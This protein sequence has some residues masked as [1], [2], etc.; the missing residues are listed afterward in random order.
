MLKIRKTI[1]FMISI[2]MLI[3][4]FGSMSVLAAENG[5]NGIYYLTKAYC[6]SSSGVIDQTNNG[7][8]QIKISQGVTAKIVVQVK[9]LSQM[10]S[11]RLSYAQNGGTL[12]IKLS[13]L[14]D[15]G[16][17]SGTV[18]LDTT[19]TGIESNYNTRLTEGLAFSTRA[20]G[21]E[22]YLLV[23]LICG[24]SRDN[25]SYID[26][27][28]LVGEPADFTEPVMHITFDEAGT[29]T[30]SFTANSGGTIIENGIVS[31]V[32][33]ENG[34]KA[35]LIENN[36]A[37]NYLELPTGILNGAEAA[38]V[39]MWVKP[40]SR[41]WPFMT[42]TI[43]EG[44]QP[45][46]NEKY[47]G[48]ISSPT[49][50]TAQRYNNSG[51]RR[52][53]LIADGDYTDWKNV[54]AV[55][56]GN[57]AKIYVDGKL[58]ATD[59]TT[60][61]VKNLMTATARTWIGHANWGTGEGFSGMIDD[62]KLYGRA[63]SEDEVKK[64][65]FENAGGLE[66]PEIVTEP[67]VL[68]KS[69]GGNPILRADKDGNRLYTGDPA[70]VVI[71]DTVYLAVGHDVPGG[72]TYNMPDWLYFTSK[73]MKNWTYGGVLMGTTAIPWRDG[74]NAAYASQMTPYTNKAT[75]ETKYYF[76]FSTPY[77]PE[78]RAV[79]SLGV[80]VADSP[81]GEYTVVGSEPLVS[82]FLTE[83]GKNHG[84]QDIDPTIWI[85]T[86]ENG[87]E[88]R[89]LIWGNVNCF[90]AELNE[91]MVSIKDMD[92]DG[93][94]TF[95][96]DIKEITFDEIQ[97]EQI[98]TE[99]PWLYRR[100]DANG[101]Y[102]G[103]YY[104]F[105]AWGWSEKMGYATADNPWGPWTFQE[106]IMENTLTSNTNH[107]SVIDFKGKTYFIYHNGALPGGTGGTRSVCVQEL[108]FNQDGSIIK[109]EESS[110]GL[111]GTTSIIQ[112]TDNKYLGHDHLDNPQDAGEG[113]YIF[114]IKTYDAENGTDTQWEI[115]PARSV[116]E[117]ENADCFVSL[118]AVNKEGYFIR[119]NEN[120]YSG[121]VNTKL[122]SDKSG[123][124]GS[125]M[126]YKTVKALDGSDG[127]SFE[128]VEYP[129]QFLCVSDGRMTIKAPTVDS[130][131]ACSFK[132]SAPISDVPPVSS[133]TPA[134]ETENM[135]EGYV[136]HYSF[137]GDY[138]NAVET[139]DH[140]KNDTTGVLDATKI[141]AFAPKDSISGNL[142]LKYSSAH[143]KSGKSV[144][145]TD[146]DKGIAIDYMMP[147][148]TSYTV[149]YWAKATRVQDKN[150]RAQ[151]KN[152]TVMFDASDYST[153]TY[154]YLYSSVYSTYNEFILRDGQEEQYGH[155][156][157][158]EKAGYN[159]W[160]MY[161]YTY[162]ALTD[163]AQ[164]Y[165]NGKPAE[166]TVT[167][168]GGA[169]NALDRDAYL[170]IGVNPWSK[171]DGAFSGYLDELFIYE[172]VLTAEEIETAYNVLKDKG[173]GMNS[174]RTTVFAPTTADSYRSG[175]VYGRGIEL[176]HQQNEEDNGKLITTS[177]YYSGSRMDGNE[178]FPIFLSEDGGTSWNEISGVHDTE[179]NLEKFYPDKD[180]KYIVE[181]EIGGTGAKK[182]Y[183]MSK[184]SM[185]HQPHLYELP[186]DWEGAGL[187]AGTV[188]CA[189]LTASVD[190]T[191]TEPATDFD[192]NLHTRIDLYY[193]TDAC[194]TWD[195]LGHVT[196]GG[197]S[198]VDWGD[199]IWEPNL[200]LENGKLYC[201]YSD[202]RGY[203]EQT[204]H[205]QVP[206]D[207]DTAQIIVAQGSA[208][209]KNWE[210]PFDVVNY[211]GENNKFRPGM[212]VVTKLATGE[213]VVAYEGMGMGDPITYTYYKISNGA[214]IESWDATATD[215]NVPG[216]NRGSPYCATLPTGE[217][218]FG[219]YGSENV[220][221]N[222]DNLVTNTFAQYATGVV[223]GYSR[224]LFPMRDGRLLVVSGGRSYPNY[225]QTLE[226]GVVDIGLCSDEG[227]GL[228]V[229]TEIPVRDQIP[230]RA[231]GV[232][233]FYPSITNGKVQFQLNQ[234]LDTPYE[235]VKVRVTN[236]ATD[237]VYEDNVT[238][239]KTAVGTRFNGA[240]LNTQTVVTKMAA[241]DLEQ[242]V[243][244][245]YDLEGNFLTTTNSSGQ[246]ENPSVTPAPE[247]PTPTPI[248]EKASIA[249]A[250]LKDGNASFV[251][252]N[253]EEYN[254]VKA[255]IAEYGENGTLASV[256]VQDVQ[257][258]GTAQ[259]VSIP[260]TKL[261]DN[262]NAKLMVW[263]DMKPVAEAVILKSITAPSDY[264]AYYSFDGNYQN[265][266]SS[267]HTTAHQVGVMAINKNGYGGNTIY[268]GSSPRNAASQENDPIL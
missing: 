244:D 74:N 253:A 90:V 75:G 268:G 218:V 178:Y 164:I 216:C 91:D 63:L 156:F 127:V 95:G 193:S 110:I 15:A 33:S 233:I 215:L 167:N 139:K 126:S 212:P 141:D 186:E 122:A 174:V 105:G 133:P 132:I 231:K 43:T 19:V 18:L 209:G 266:A 145:L 34:T 124:L 99:A 120:L 23:E 66:A 11:A 136:A 188:L 121:D 190:T 35:L 14:A 134:P 265:A 109:L 245:I 77:N 187:K 176:Q 56:D 181:G 24:G 30:G 195:F 227:E 76:Y 8:P 102:Y 252:K 225:M 230:Q 27:I 46:K 219:A 202:E 59:N 114:D 258:T 200:I 159:N 3:T 21:G 106:I 62:F 65:A 41:G 100:Q 92:G 206:E 247:E 182:A 226:A 118:Q 224:S 198:R 54:V 155:L 72:G 168:S 172:K 86:D 196:D 78:G 25:N 73:D 96:T 234:Y 1:A 261:N 137:D 107:P 32:D 47:L 249:N 64:I 151:M 262:N 221:V 185:R 88:H 79:H 166:E 147:E 115:V 163:T 80:A 205:V 101:N 44:A 89:Y 84:W 267:G 87:I 162:D 157:G 67:V 12:G 20:S 257:V 153:K 103:K 130:Y 154:N 204:P 28:E 42:T 93:E 148:N 49:S 57:Y 256:K 260:Y 213:F 113:E 239:R 40:V 201:F 31:Y 242:C 160:Q 38:T 228:R 143:S 68:E 255:Y 138:K 9:S 251:L 69:M 248:L 6:I 197:E 173:E 203:Y 123:T 194:K 180:G 158:K 2:V 17:E 116:P 214:D 51:T 223:T 58:A 60:I 175:V 29:G 13:A 117:N 217:I 10:K 131:S 45:N 104:M 81:A 189:G 169:V 71:D 211:H 119:S 83:T 208:D 142:T 125:K 229:G 236:K 250:V 55:Y 94:I 53:D 264:A 220:F 22:Q 199:A 7:N 243:I 146:G 50:F 70:A 235:T 26:Y 152:P 150:G 241:S 37:G 112:T 183:G 98:Y 191:A 207:D 144:N 170:Y 5:I 259:T 165:I 85:D 161:T 4:C 108:K 52:G 97:G 177:E 184:W 140:I 210:E 36:A 16:D 263:K 192:G 128:S 129:N 171:T 238:M 232:K 48:L 240:R 222:S 179:N 39:S 246:P 254:E 111:G 149:S 61:P 237:G 135:P 82:G